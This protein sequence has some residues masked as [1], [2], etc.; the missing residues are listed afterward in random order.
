MPSPLPMPT[1]PFDHFHFVSVDDIIAHA[2]LF[3]P[4][5][6]FTI[7]E[8]ARIRGRMVAPPH[9]L[10]VAA[11]NRQTAYRCGHP[12]ERGL[13]GFSY[14]SLASGAL[15]GALATVYEVLK[16]EGIVPQST[17]PCCEIPIPQLAPSPQ[18]ES[19]PMNR[20]LISAHD[21]RLTIDTNPM[22]TRERI[23][24][25]PR[26]VYAAND[27]EA[28]TLIY[29]SSEAQKFLATPGNTSFFVPLTTVFGGT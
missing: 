14:E 9:V 13:Y 28:R 17:N 26:V 25:E 21:S 22:S 3:V 4:G 19:P 20:Y 8:K 1:A 7:S 10:E 5:F 2:R 27:T 15:V 29:A 11:L 12:Y 16:V 18:Q 6:K 24:L 23:I